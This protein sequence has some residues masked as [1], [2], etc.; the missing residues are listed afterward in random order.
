ML[1]PGDAKCRSRGPSV[2]ESPLVRFLL[3][4]QDAHSGIAPRQRLAYHREAGPKAQTRLNFRPEV[5]PAD[6]CRLAPVTR[7][8]PAPPR[9]PWPMDPTVR[10]R[11]ISPKNLRV[12]YASDY[13]AGIDFPR[14]LGT[15]HRQPSVRALCT[16]DP[17]RTRSYSPRRQSPRDPC[18]RLIVLP[19]GRK[20]CAERRSS[21]SRVS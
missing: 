14:L 4:S 8:K 9:N 1:S 18:G 5:R 17:R 10:R 2:Y 13:T 12:I 19:G 3:T 20:P 16:I 6:L 11:E 15:P 21:S 7:A